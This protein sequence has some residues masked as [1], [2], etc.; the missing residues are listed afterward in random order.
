MPYNSNTITISWCA[1]DYDQT[2][3]HFVENSEP[4][5]LRRLG[6]RVQ[7]AKEVT[8]S[9][10]YDVNGSYIKD[11]DA[12]G[13]VEIPADR[14]NQIK[15]FID[16]Y[17]TALEGLTISTGIGMTINEAY[18]AMMVASKR[19]GDRI[20]MWTDD[21][22][23][24]MGEDSEEESSPLN[25]YR[26]GLTDED[27]KHQI[28][29]E[30]VNLDGQNHAGSV[31]KAE[32]TVEEK[33]HHYAK[34][35]HAHQTLARSPQRQQLRDGVLQ[36]LQR[37]AERAPQLEK[38]KD[39]APELHESILHSLKALHMMAKELA[40]EPHRV[41]LPEEDVSK[42][43]TEELMDS[44][45]IKDATG[46]AS[47]PLHNTVEGFMTGL[48]AMPKGSPARGKHITSH[49]NH[50]PFLAALKAHP[51]GPQ[52]HSMLTAHMN[53]AANAGFK[54]GA[55]VA[56][57][58][59]ELD[60]T[61]ME[62]NASVVCP[63]QIQQTAFKHKKTGKVVPT[64]SFHNIDFL[65]KKDDVFDWEAGFLNHQGKYCSREEAHQLVTGNKTSSAPLMS[66]DM[67]ED[68]GKKEMPKLPGFHYPVGT[69]KDQKMLVKEPDGHLRWHA[70]K[71]G[72]IMSLDGHPI[73]AKQPGHVH[74]DKKK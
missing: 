46:L 11:G 9:W 63:N 29:T 14:T 74:E 61:F 19:G 70:M 12:C 60:K 31:E 43:L 45:L 72:K 18:K 27:A 65:P 52:V 3:G 23:R 4:E 33:L 32:G 54:P 34:H 25:D 24:E 56:V 44:P 49:M 38:L 47:P 36:I 58:K 8:K 42:S 66:E 16:Q 35:H 28:M 51:Q 21:L 2:Q 30:G 73:S 67:P 40:I 6:F 55:T 5:M 20:V 53:S 7:A 57:A 10:L 68:F 64:G 50:P 48:K 39:V 1:D 62:P 69:E 15:R 13:I 41:E 71:S 22:D 59:E 37:V 17:A 26:D